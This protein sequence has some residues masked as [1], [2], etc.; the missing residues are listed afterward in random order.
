MRADVLRRELEQAG[1]DEMCVGLRIRAGCLALLVV[2]FAAPWAALPC[3]AASGPEIEA[4][5]RA[6]LDEFFRK[7]G[8]ARAFG[9]R[10]VAILVFPTVVKAGLGIGGEY[11]EGAL[12][13]RGQAAAYYNIISGSIGFQLGAQARSVIIVFMTEQALAQ[14]QATDGWKVGIDGSITIIAIGVGGAIDTNSITSPIVG[15]IFDQ[16]GLMYNLTL[17]GSKISRIDR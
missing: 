1:G 17:E 13:I 11:G 8:F 5:V 12:L 10:A 7:V 2:V 16:K 6:T 9:N 14:F 15:F 3:K 4:E